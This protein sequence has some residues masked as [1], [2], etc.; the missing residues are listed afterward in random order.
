MMRYGVLFLFLI[1]VQFSR[2]QTNEEKALNDVKQAI[3]L[4]GR[5]SLDSAI[6]L[7]DEAVKF[8][9]EG[10]NIGYEL[11]IAHYTRGDYDTARAVL[12]KLLDRKDV[13]SSVYQLLGN[14]YD[15]LKNVEKA[16]ATYLNGIV[17]FP[18]AGELYLE[19]GTMYLSRKEYNPAIAYYEKGIQ[20]DPGFASNYYW[21]AKIYCNSDEAV[22]GMIYGEI[23]LNLERNSKRT[24]EI[25][26]LLFDTYKKKIRFPRDSSFQVN[27]SKP[28]NYVVFDTVKNKKKT[29]FVKAV[30]EPM[31][32]LALLNEKTVDLNSLSRIRKYFV[33]SY[34]KTGTYQNYPNALFDFQYRVLKAGHWDA[35]SRWILFKGDEA[36]GNEWVNA[37]RQKWDDFVKWF[38]KNQMVLDATYKFYR[39][40]YD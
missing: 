37:N 34:F 4:E 28:G 36:E 3:I 14:T 8:Y 9:P 5:G 29:P 24:D 12:E 40:Q 16:I 20:S 25:S 30:Y 19:M 11:A 38:T 15:K 10:T 33:E 18:E 35:Y 17:K 22:W 6:N 32:M 39:A 13:F 31:L 1:A 21:A 7:L 23:F 2:A 26:K 27:F